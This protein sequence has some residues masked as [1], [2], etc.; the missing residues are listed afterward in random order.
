MGITRKYLAVS[1]ASVFAL[2][3]IGCGQGFR[4]NSKATEVGSAGLGGKEPV[5][6]DDQLAKAQAASE[7]AQKAMAAADAA[8]AEIMDSNG[9]IKI[10]I[11]G[12]KSVN[13]QTRTA[14]LLAPLVDKL[15]GVF[16][17][18]FAKVGLVKDQ[19]N[20][21]RLLLA[22]ALAKVQAAG[23]TQAQLDL[24]RAQMAKIDA[25]EAQFSASMHLLAGKLDLATAALDKLVASA[26]SSIPGIGAIA[27]IFVDMFLMA[28]VK[29]LINSVKAKLL[30]I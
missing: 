7:E 28:D 18:L 22:D 12:T 3:S 14:G 24:I 20:K 4:T 26:T 30:A 15:N 19:F 16:D 13:S 21:A 23:G 9:N 1:I 2:S 17:Q 10:N 27:G 25:L 11:F 8:L 6:I 29:N 5:N